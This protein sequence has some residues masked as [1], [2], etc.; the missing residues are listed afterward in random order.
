MKI[1]QLGEFGIVYDVDPYALPENAFSG[2]MNVRFT[3]RGVQSA[4]G[5][6]T[7]LSQA[8]LTP[9]WIKHFGRTEGPIWVYADENDAYAVADGVHTKITRLSGAYTGD[10]QERWNSSVLS[11]IGIFNN[12]YDVPQMWA[13][14]DPQY[15]FQDLANWPSNLRAKVVRSYKNFLVAGNLTEDGISLPFRVRWSHPAEPGSVPI[16]WDP[17]DP[18]KDTGESDLAETSDEVVDFLSMGD[19]LIAYR[20]ES[21]W[22]M[23]YIGPPYVF[24]IFRLLDD[25]GILWRDCAAA[26][27]K[28]HFV[29]TRNDIVVHNGQRNG[30]QSLLQSRLKR[31]LF[32]QISAQNQRNCFVV[33]NR[34]ENEIWF[35]YPEAGETYANVALI[36]N[37]LSGGIG[38]TEL[39]RIPFADSGP[40]RSVATTD[41]TWG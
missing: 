40:T 2:G 39:P 36:W 37:W 28:G 17:A 1:G 10:A 27:P 34:D 14:F 31:W 35:C 19:L 7:A 22:A 21:T 25:D 3:E 6:G 16:S 33:S 18:T 32:S 15:Q 23:Q 29:V 4:Q 9:K 13:A 24:R 41:D 12:A 5:W 38:F 30:G 11:G 26:Y 8:A 20:E